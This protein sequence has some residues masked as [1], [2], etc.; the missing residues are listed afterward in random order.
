MILVSSHCGPSL[1]QGRRP[2][3]FAVVDR[4][5]CSHAQTSCSKR[6]VFV[7]HLERGSITSLHAKTGLRHSPEDDSSGMTQQMTTRET[8]IEVGEESP[9]AERAGVGLPSREGFSFSSTQGWKVSH[10]WVL[11]RV[12]CPEAPWNSF[13]YSTDPWGKRSQGSYPWRSENWSLTSW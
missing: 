2:K 1:G 5:D 12:P 4:I 9:G 10:P 6:P 8:A 7:S 11:G 3:A 13:V